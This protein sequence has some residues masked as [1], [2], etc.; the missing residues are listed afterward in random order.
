LCNHVYFNFA[1]ID[2]FAITF[3]IDTIKF[4]FP[5]YMLPFRPCGGAIKGCC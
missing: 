4:F 1:K 5:P 3:L 2:Y